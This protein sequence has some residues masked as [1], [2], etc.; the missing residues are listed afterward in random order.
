MKKSTRQYFKKCIRF[1]KNHHP[2]NKTVSQ[3]SRYK[4]QNKGINDES[5]ADKS[6]DAINC[7]K[8]DKLSLYKEIAKQIFLY[9][10][11][12]I[13]TSKLI[14]NLRTALTLENVPYRR[15]KLPIE[16]DDDDILTQKHRRNCLFIYFTLCDR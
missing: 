14:S 6:N 5:F 11:T 7:E 15:K 4:N 9:Q 8:M 2:T 3:S 13:T 16:S 10:K 12:A 1:Y